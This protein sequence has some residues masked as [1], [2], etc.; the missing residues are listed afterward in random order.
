[1]R[2]PAKSSAKQSLLPVSWKARTISSSGITGAVCALLDITYEFRRFH[3][4]KLSS[5]LP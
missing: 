4:E 3:K 1:L 2:Y 5:G